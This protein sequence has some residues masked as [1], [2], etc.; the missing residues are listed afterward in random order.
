MGNEAVASPIIPPEKIHIYDDHRVDKSLILGPY[1]EGSDVSLLCEVKGGRP[2]PKV[3]W[4]LEN[5]V[6]DDSY[7]VNR[8]A[9]SS[10]ISHSERRPTAFARKTDLPG[11]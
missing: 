5:T 8:T 9:L 2:R 3:T 6:I 10:I 11:Q 1:N 7:D 4:F